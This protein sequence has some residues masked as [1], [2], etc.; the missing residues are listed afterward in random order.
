MLFSD[1]SQHVHRKQCLL[2]VKASTSRAVARMSK[3][4]SC[5]PFEWFTVLLE[6]VIVLRVY[7][8]QKQKVL[9]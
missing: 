8:S 6:V 7:Y 5:P 4:V 9:C 2:L 1:L 3:R